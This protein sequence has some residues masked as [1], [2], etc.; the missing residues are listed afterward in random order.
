MRMM[1]KKRLPTSFLGISRSGTKSFFGFIRQ[2]TCDAIKNERIAV[3]PAL[4]L[5]F[6][7]D[8][9][10]VIEF[11]CRLKVMRDELE[12]LRQHLVVF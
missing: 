5:T 2:R 4:M 12:V 6:V 8:E 10:Q 3:S 7:K 9:R 1:A 11:G